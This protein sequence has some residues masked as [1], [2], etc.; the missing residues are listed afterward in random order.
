MKEGRKEGLIPVQNWISL[1][2]FRSHP[3]G[4]IHRHTESPFRQHGSRKAPCSVTVHE[5]IAF[6]QKYMHPG[7]RS[8][9]PGDTQSWTL[10][11]IASTEASSHLPLE[12]RCRKHA[13][14]G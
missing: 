11:P 6:V 7:R 2:Q 10:T 3:N 9:A 14:R 5:V 8:V 13:A 12:S 1:V 4:H